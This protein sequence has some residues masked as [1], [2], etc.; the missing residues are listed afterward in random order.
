LGILANLA[1]LAQILIRNVDDRSW[2]AYLESVTDC[3]LRRGL[4]QTLALV[5]MGSALLFTHSR[6]GIASSLLGITALT[7]SAVSAP[8]LRSGWRTSFVALAA[9][10]TTV[11]IALNGATFL[12]RVADTSVEKDLRFDIDSG[13]A[14]AI[15]SNYLLGTGLGTFKYVYAPY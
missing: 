10:G 1:L 5:I 13:T 4:W 2:R 11:V 15:G 14:S 12:S 9:L 8:S 6:G 7:V 3:L